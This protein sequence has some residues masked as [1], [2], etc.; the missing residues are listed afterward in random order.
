MSANAAVNL[1]GP[2]CDASQTAEYQVPLAYSTPLS[3]DSGIIGFSPIQPILESDEYVL[4]CTPALVSYFEKRNLWT[5]AET[6][7]GFYAESPM[8]VFLGQSRYVEP[9]PVCV[10][11]GSLVGSEYF[12]L[13]F[14]QLTR[15]TQLD[16]FESNMQDLIARVNSGT[17]LECSDETREL[18]K[19]VAETI[20]QDGYIQDESE[21]ANS[22]VADFFRKS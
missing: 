3:V 19:Q 1:Y 21:W 7:S 16:S 20:E 12:S 13:V 14:D 5:I 18:A 22:L 15:K 9:E 4:A 11:V 17:P 10:G 8:Y 2:D 6:D